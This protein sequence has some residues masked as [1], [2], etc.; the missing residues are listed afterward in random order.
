[1]PFLT[2]RDWFVSTL[3]GNS[4]WLIA[5]SYYVYI[6]FLGYRS[7]NILSNTKLFL[8]P[9]VPLVLFYL[10][11]LLFNWNMT[12]DLMYFYHYRVL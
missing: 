3:F 10:G 6:T 7:L 12:R 5:L 1:M 2:D 4:L 11:T 9:L 8:Y